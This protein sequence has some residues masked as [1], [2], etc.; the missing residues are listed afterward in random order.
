MSMEFIF[1]SYKQEKSKNNTS[2]SNWSLAS[3]MEENDVDKLN[4]TFGSIEAVC[5]I[6]HSVNLLDLVE[7]TEELRGSIKN[8]H[9]FL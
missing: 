6:S 8:L 5:S 7:E 9:P 1:V 2:L 4:A 3:D